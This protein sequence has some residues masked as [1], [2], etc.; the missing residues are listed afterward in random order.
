MQTTFQD[1]AQDDSGCRRVDSSSDDCATPTKHDARKR[2]AAASSWDFTVTDWSRPF[3]PRCARG[4]THNEWPGHNN[5]SNTGWSAARHNRDYDND[6]RDVTMARL[7]PQMSAK[8][9]RLRRVAMAVAGDMAV[10]G[11]TL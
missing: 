7:G 10:I 5:A 11:G 9:T 2:V 8:R 6:K 3:T 1:N 4:T